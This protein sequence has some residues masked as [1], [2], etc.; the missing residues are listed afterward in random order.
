MLPN[1]YTL[2]DGGWD[3]TAVVDCVGTGPYGDGQGGN[4]WRGCNV[5]PAAFA[6]GTQCLPVECSVVAGDNPIDVL[7]GR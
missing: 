6:T 4:R 7:G 1:C 5:T 2:P 3:D